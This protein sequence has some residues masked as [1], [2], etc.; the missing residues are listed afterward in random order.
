M[1][2]LNL[3]TLIGRLGRDAELKYLNTGTPLVSFSV[4]VNGSKKD[5]DRYVDV[6]NWIDVNYFG[7]G[8][9]AVNQYLLKGKQIAIQGELRQEKWEKDG[10][11]RSRIVVT[12]HSVQ[13][14]R[15]REE[16]HSGAPAR[17]GERRDSRPPASA[18]AAPQPATEGESDGFTD[19][20]PF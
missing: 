20:I 12:A 14:L 1:N 7:K 15:S 13:L 9:E 3:V 8:A 5:G 19:D 18:R 17:E 11:S 4:C 6:P 16:G 10:E 2:D